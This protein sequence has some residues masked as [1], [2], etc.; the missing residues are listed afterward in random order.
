MKRT[1]IK[2]PLCGKKI[3]KFNISKHI[4]SH[5]NGNY[6]KHKN[7]YHL[8]HDDLF[9]KFCG[10]EYKNKNSL[11]QHEVR[12]KD[13][14]TGIKEYPHNKGKNNGMYGKIAWNKGL[15]KETDERVKMA[16]ISISDYYKNNH[17]TFLEKN[18][19]EETKKLLKEKALNN[20]YRRRSKK[21]IKY[22]KKNGDIT[23]LDS[24]Y[25]VKVAD[26]LEDLNIKWGSPDPIPWIDTSGVKHNYFSDF[27]LI[28]YDIYLD[29]KNSYCF[30]S[31]KEKI[32]YI[33]KNY[34]N[35]YFI[36][37]EDINKEFILNL[38]KK[39]KN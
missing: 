15:T 1:R 27:Y 31:Q 3:S 20:P 21:R 10:R 6:D 33:E 16:S 11:A 29:P 36:K 8:D 35:V 34:K 14:P 38:I 2:C 5:K 17:G 24:S 9:C 32:D 22:V 12:C 13:N 4:R 39:S 7:M 25:E 37:N 23:I 30:K 19:S 28:D 26:I 18:H